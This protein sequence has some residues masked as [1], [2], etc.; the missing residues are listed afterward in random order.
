MSEDRIKVST[1]DQCN[2]LWQGPVAPP[3]TCPQCKTATSWTAGEVGKQAGMVGGR[4]F[5]PGTNTPMTRVF[6]CEACGKMTVVRRG[7]PAPEA[8]AKCGVAGRFV[9]ATGAALKDPPKETVPAPPD[10]E[11]P[12]P[13]LF[14]DAEDVRNHPT[15]DEYRGEW[16][17][18]RVAA[19]F[20]SGKFA[21]VPA[22]CDELWAA[23]E[24]LYDE[25]R[26]RG[27]LP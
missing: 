5:V 21:D 17:A 15:A 25:G 7:A 22:N 2:A 26:K 16:I 19:F 18:E 4:V 8:C 23:A 24:R 14:L 11:K 3:A 27:H 20:D 13:R 10:E 6:L 12:D 1:C 9:E